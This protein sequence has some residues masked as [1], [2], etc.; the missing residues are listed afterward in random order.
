MAPFFGMDAGTTADQRNAVKALGTFG[1]A[2]SSRLVSCLKRMED[3]RTQIGR[4]NLNPKWRR[5]WLWV[6]RTSEWRLKK[7]PCVRRE[8]IELVL[9]KTDHTP[10]MLCDLV[11]KL[12]VL[13]LN[14]QERVW[15]I[16]EDWRI[17]GAPDED[18]AKVREKN[19]CGCSL[20][21][22]T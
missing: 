17:S 13:V 3:Y 9:T 14:D 20:S 2:S 1:Q 19:S 11:S 4:Y 22:R 6:R 18:I 7:D 16:I 8:M 12:H 10:E 15:K 21:S 5:E